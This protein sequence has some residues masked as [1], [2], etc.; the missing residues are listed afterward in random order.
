M[1]RPGSI[2]SYMCAYA[3]QQRFEDFCAGSPH[4]ALEQEPSTPSSS[5]MASANDDVDTTTTTTSTTA[6]NNNRWRLTGRTIVVT[7]GTQG[8][9]AAVVTECLQL[10]AAMVI[11]CSRSKKAVDNDATSSSNT[12]TSR[13]IHVDECDLSTIDGRAKLV[14]ACRQL[15]RPIH[16]LV[17]NVGVNVRK[18]IVEQTIDEYKTIFRTNVDAA[19]HLT[20]DVYMAG[21]FAKSNCSIVN[22]SSAAGLASSGTGIAYAMS[23]AAL[24]QFTKTL[25]MEWARSGIRVN[26]ICP[27][28]TLT[29]MLAQ[30]NATN[31]TASA[32]ASATATAGSPAH[33]AAH[34]PLG[35]LAI[36][37]EMAGPICF[38]LLDASSYVTGQV[39]A[40]DGGLTA[41]GYAG[42]CVVTSYQQTS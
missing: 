3:E 6:H 25:A 26:A 8:I 12:N 13:T 34:T 42:P 7:G 20:R 30:A 28:M 4:P 36:P 21:C 41:Q 17:N 16:G 11:Y 22:V 33:A 35:R 24:N 9:G 31:A 10:D 14:A 32:T 23:K 19:Y 15:G 38:L 2:G 29:P 37:S 1:L 39:W 5:A 40:V 18:S 27:W